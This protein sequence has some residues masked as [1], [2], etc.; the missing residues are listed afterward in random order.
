MARLGDIH[1]F[2]HSINISCLPAKPAPGWSEETIV[3]APVLIAL[4]LSPVIQPNSQAMVAVKY[5]E[6]EPR[7][8]AWLDI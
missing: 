8:P 1:A 6:E 3:T 4:I 2:I 7:V 5:Y